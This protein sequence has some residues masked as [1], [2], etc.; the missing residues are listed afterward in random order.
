VTDGDTVKVLTTDQQLLRIRLA[1]IDAPEKS[2]A[3]G[4]RAKQAMSEL[5][6][7]EDVELRVYGLDKYGRNLATVFVDGKDVCLEEVRL[8]Y[9][10]VY[11]HYI[12]QAPA[13]IQTSYQQAEI[14]ARA[15]RRSVAARESC[16]D[17][18]LGLSTS[19]EI[20]TTNDL[21]RTY[22]GHYEHQSIGN[23]QANPEMAALA[24]QHPF[25]FFET[26]VQ[27]VRRIGNDPILASP[28]PALEP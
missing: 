19:A 8:G 26:I 1:W 3:F 12:G 6:F 25:T 5:V 20:M 10:W 13:D 24:E 15:Q 2:Q 23:N 14:E 7:G 16:T 17:P 9:A 28:V 18:A 27:V 11:Q 4:Q 21:C 22:D